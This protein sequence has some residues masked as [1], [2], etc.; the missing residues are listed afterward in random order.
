MLFIKNA[1]YLKDFLISIE[2]SSGEKGIADFKDIIQ[3]SGYALHS[4]IHNMLWLCRTVR[5]FLINIEWP[6]ESCAYPDSKIPCRCSAAG[7]SEIQS[8][9]P[10]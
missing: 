8:L 5:R 2:F 7:S 3:K 10:R 9:L 4:T 1:K 6:V